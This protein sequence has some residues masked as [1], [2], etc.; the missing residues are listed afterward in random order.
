M[1][2]IREIIK[3]SSFKLDE[4]NKK[5]EYF[6][7]MCQQKIN[8]N[9]R[10]IVCTACN[11]WIHKRCVSIPWEKAVKNK[12]VFKC[13]N[14][15]GK[16]EAPKVA[17]NPNMMDV[18]KLTSTVLLSGADA[19]SFGGDI[20]NTDLKSLENGGWVT[21]GIISL[22]FGNIQQYVNGNKLALVEPSITQ[23]LRKS[24]D[25]CTVAKTVEDL[26]LKEM[27]YVFFPVN[28]NDNVDGEGGSHWSLLVYISDKR[29]VKFYHHDPIS[30]ANHRHANELIKNLSKANTFFKSKPKIEEVVIPEQVNGYDCGIYSD[31]CGSVGK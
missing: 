9:F 14:C 1:K 26:K 12:H 18:E 11:K 6:C 28:N 5:V 31:I 17:N 23:I 16:D 25:P 10:T 15:E 13:K 20:S 29:H 30:G 7:G 3:K 8:I 22:I 4:A 21:D 19:R 2:E 27:D 24:P